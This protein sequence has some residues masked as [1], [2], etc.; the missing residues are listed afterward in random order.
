LNHSVGSA[1]RRWSRVHSDSR[2]A[3]PRVTLQQ[4]AVRASW[5]ERIPTAD[6]NYRCCADSYVPNG[7]AGHYEVQGNP[8]Q[9]NLSPKSLGSAEKRE[10][11]FRI[12]PILIA[13]QNQLKRARPT[14]NPWLQ[15]ERWVNDGGVGGEHYAARLRA[16]RAR[17]QGINNF[18]IVNSR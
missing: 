18:A 9:I 17:S 11:E 12:W 2:R 13:N 14:E 10:P 3:G 1:L 4:R 6:S 15:I 16:D 7:R 5:R 8:L